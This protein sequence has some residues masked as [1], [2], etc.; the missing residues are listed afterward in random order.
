MISYEI[1]LDVV[2]L[3]I[4]ILRWMITIEKEIARIAAVCEVRH[5]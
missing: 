5:G 1:G 2:A 3:G 4:F